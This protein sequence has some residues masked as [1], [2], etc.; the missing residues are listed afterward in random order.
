[1]ATSD[2]IFVVEVGEST[3]TVPFQEN[4]TLGALIS[5]RNVNKNVTVK[6][7]GERVAN[8]YSLKPGDQVQMM[9][10]VEAGL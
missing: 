3:Q 1:M 2:P 5:A 7:N 4:M 9:P 10:N 6:V 8:D